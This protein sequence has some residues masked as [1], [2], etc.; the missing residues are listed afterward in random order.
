M[1][2][3]TLVLLQVALLTVLAAPASASFPGR[4]GVLAVSHTCEPSGFDDGIDIL[5]KRG[6]LKRNL[7]PCGSETFGPDF[8][9]D[10]RRLVYIDGPA[11]VDGPRAAAVISS[12]DGSDVTRLPYGIVPLTHD[13][14]SFSPTAGRILFA[15][16][17]EDGHR[18]IIQARVDGGGS[19]SLVGGDPFVVDP[20][21]SPAA[22]RMLLTDLEEGIRVASTRTGELGQVVADGYDPDWAP[23][24]RRLVYAERRGIF[25]VRADG[26]GRRV[27]YRDGDASAHSPVWSPNGR[28][29]AWVRADLRD[30]ASGQAAAEYSLWRMRA[31]GGSAQRLAGLGRLVFDFENE[32]YFDVT[33]DLAWQPLP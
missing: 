4:N 13:G 14:P 3:M 26:Q 32:E 5:G 19:R 8:S 15:H 1:R 9:P 22:G 25:T 10:G 12:L 28:W 7:T 23:G 27:L 33:P 16:G 24:G 21:W 2:V 17:G 11:V 20:R 30:D 18:D 6:R 29:I 31:R